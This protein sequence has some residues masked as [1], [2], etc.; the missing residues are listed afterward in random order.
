MQ[1][2]VY[3]GSIIFHSPKGLILFEIAFGAIFKLGISGLG[4][5]CA[6][7]EYRHGERAIRNATMP[8]ITMRADHGP[9]KPIQVTSDEDLLRRIELWTACFRTLVG[10]RDG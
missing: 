10:L 4:M 3:H 7:G 1:A 6:R 9:T 8:V 2:C 5:A